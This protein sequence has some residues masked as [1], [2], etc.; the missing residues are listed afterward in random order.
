MRTTFAIAWNQV[1]LIY[2]SKA[3]LA[4]MFLMPMLLTVIFGMGAG[5][6]SGSPV[7]RVYPLGVVDQD[8]S[9]ASA[10][11]VEALG[12]AGPLRVRLL[13]REELDRQFLDKE[14]PLGVLI[15]A[16]Y[17]QA[18]AEGKSPAVT[19][20]SAPGSNLE[21][22]GGQAVRRAVARASRDYQLARQMAANPAD[23]TQVA[24]AFAKLQTER[25]AA[26]VTVAHETVAATTGQSISRAEIMGQVSLGFTVMFVM[27]VIFMMGGV[28]LQER[29]DGTWGRLLTTP[30]S[31]LGLLAG[32][33]LSFLL[34]GLIQFCTLVG[35]SRLL[36][37][38]YWGPL[39]QLLVMASAMILAAAGLG[40]FL[41]GLVRTADQQRTISTIVVV[42]T[43]MLGGVYW[44]L[45]AVSPTMQKIGYLTPQA[46][47]MD[48]LREVM[49]RGGA[50]D[51][52]SLPLAVLLALAAIFTTAGL[53]RV[54]YE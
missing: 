17:Q 37:Q 31:R 53:F 44:P 33:L 36:F 48:G 32:Y 42:A 38:I 35:L 45:E 47:A 24:E 54:R 7:G 1:R 13:T 27:M 3:S 40:L 22:A 51:A 25:E 14:L 4:M 15:P 12:K 28:F 18:L 26:P 20:V 30:V 34:I 6:G 9:F 49:L 41:A 19:L 5:G 46:W 43:S 23:G 39:P 50:W 16:G 8:G 29:Q 2:K 11:L 21:I 10:Q 52:L